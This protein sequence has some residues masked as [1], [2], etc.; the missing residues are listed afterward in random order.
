MKR[1]RPWPVAPILWAIGAALTTLSMVLDLLSRRWFWGGFAGAAT[2]AALV[3]AV[4]AV[5]VYGRKR[6]WWLLAEHQRALHR[7]MAEIRTM[8]RNGGAS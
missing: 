8:V 2:A 4:A 1:R 6:N 5:R 7:A 3:A